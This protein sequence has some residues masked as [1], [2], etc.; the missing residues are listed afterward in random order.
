MKAK[1][2]DRL[3]L[4]L[5]LHGEIVSLQ[6]LY[7]NIFVVC[8]YHIHHNHSGGHPQARRLLRRSIGR[9]RLGRC[10]C[11]RGLS[12]LRPCPGRN[13][14]KKDDAARKPKRPIGHANILLLAGCAEQTNAFIEVNNGILQ[15]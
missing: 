2:T 5:F 14:E 10:T 7:R 9:G 8:G 1:C 11:G 15:P 13:Y 6:V 4:P 3:R 12:L